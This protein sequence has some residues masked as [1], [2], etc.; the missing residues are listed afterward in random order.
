MILFC[1]LGYIFKKG[2]LGTPQLSTILVLHSWNVTEF[3]SAGTACPNPW[4]AHALPSGFS[5]TW[6]GQP[7]IGAYMNMLVNRSPEGCTSSRVDVEY[8]AQYDLHWS[9]LPSL[10]ENQLHCYGAECWPCIHKWVKDK[11]CPLA[12]ASYM[13]K[14]RN[15]APRHQTSDIRP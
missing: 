13:H 14:S 11:W 4:W 6:A 12:C 1:Q 9:S 5:A 7:L 2:K 3:T 10:G 15:I 8:T